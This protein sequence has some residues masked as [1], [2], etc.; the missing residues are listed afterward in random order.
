M[1]INVRGSFALTRLALPYLEKSPRGRVISMS[2]PMNMTELKGKT[3][4][5]ISKMGMSIVALGVAAEYK[6]KVTGNILWPATIIES[7]A[8]KNFQLGTTDLWRKAT[9]IADCTLGI[10]SENNSF[11]T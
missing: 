10:I 3:A 1:D 8:S 4:Y 9:I 2:P 7:Y 11:T 5:A 6:G